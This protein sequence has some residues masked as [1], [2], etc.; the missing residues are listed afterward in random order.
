M[1]A[2]DGILL[3]GFEEVG[4]LER[5]LMRAQNASVCAPG[6]IE[7]GEVAEKEA[8]EAEAK[9]AAE[10]EALARR[11]AREAEE[12]ADREAAAA[13][14][15]AVAAAGL[16]F[17]AGVTVEAGLTVEAAAAADLIPQGQFGDTAEYIRYHELTTFTRGADGVT[18]DDE[19]VSVH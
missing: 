13:A 18:R 15:A 16:E 1:A 9:K 10:A 8:A 17:G 3:E 12:A 14:E 5:L 4:E 19:T 2:E 6:I 11:A 7:M